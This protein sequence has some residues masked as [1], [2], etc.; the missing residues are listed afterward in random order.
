[1]AINKI[2]MLL[3][4]DAY[5]NEATNNKLIDLIKILM[6]KLKTITTIILCVSRNKS[7]KQ[8][9]KIT[10]HYSNI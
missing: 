6:A 9:I 4:D 8:K 1:M 7:N 3:P 2:T 5:N 10:S